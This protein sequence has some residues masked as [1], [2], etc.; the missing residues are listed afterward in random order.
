MA[1]ATKNDFISITSIRNFEKM[2]DQ[3]I[4]KKFQVAYIENMATRSRHKYVCKQ[5]HVEK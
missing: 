2:T 5:T 1:R 3:E 4:P